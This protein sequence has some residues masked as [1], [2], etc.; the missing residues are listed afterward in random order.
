MVK[1]TVSLCPH[2]PYPKADSAV[3][4]GTPASVISP[5]GKVRSYGWVTSFLIH[6]GYFP[7]ELVFS[8]LIQIAEVIYEAK[9]AGKSGSTTAWTWNH[10]RDATNR[11]TVLP[12]MQFV[13]SNGKSAH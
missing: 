11:F 9:W 8:C 6:A 5:M 10:Q 3:P 2:H 12:T 13:D 4:R 1:G 7:R